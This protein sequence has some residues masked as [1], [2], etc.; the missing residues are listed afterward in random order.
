MIL[1]MVEEIVVSGSD[2]K[3]TSQTMNI[4]TEN[5]ILLNLDKVA[6]VEFIDLKRDEFCRNLC[7][8]GLKRV[9][10]VVK[11]SKIISPA[12]GVTQMKEQILETAL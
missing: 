2:D 3:L 10:R 6:W 1:R 11:V 4:F 5:D 12:V 9:P 8:D 7:R